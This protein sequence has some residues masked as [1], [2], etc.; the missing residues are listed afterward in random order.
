[1]NWLTLLTVLNHSGFRKAEW[2]VRTRADTTR[3]TFSR[4]VWQLDGKPQRDTLT[5]IQRALIPQRAIKAVAL[6]YP[7][8]SKCDP[9]GTAFCNKAIPFPV[10]NDSELSA[11]TLLLR[12][13]ECVNPSNRLTTPLF[14]DDAGL[15]FLASDMDKALRDA[16][17]L[18]NPAS[19][20]T[21][22]WHSYRIR[23]ASK[24]RA[25]LTPTG[26][27]KYNDAVIQAL[28]RWKTPAS[29]ATYARYDTDV[30]AQIL[31]SVDALDITSVQYSNLPELNEQDRL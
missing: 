9:D 18:F 8:P 15:P 12:L 24:L 10:D 14:T 28:L 29:I 16:L 3:M 21:K 31:Q 7:V 17:S 11:G 26:A 23:L 20:A 1:M 6:I 27:P 22:S 4:L 25:A 13:E 19:G 30:Y 2:A 5:P